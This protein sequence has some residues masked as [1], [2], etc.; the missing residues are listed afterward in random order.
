L[1]RNFVEKLDSL[2]FRQELALALK[3][4]PDVVYQYYEREDALLLALYFKNPPGRLLRRQWSY[5]LKVFPDFSLWK[6]FVKQENI[7]IVDE[8]LE[9]EP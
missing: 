9:I 7:Q 3:Q 5:P 8:L 1:D 6:K 4:R 2:T